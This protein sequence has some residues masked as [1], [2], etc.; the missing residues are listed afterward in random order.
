MES[1]MNPVQHSEIPS[2]QRDSALNKITFIQENRPDDEHASDLRL[3]LPAGNSTSVAIGKNIALTRQLIMG[4]TRGAG[5]GSHTK[6]HKD[7]P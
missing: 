1:R 6:H 7:Y 4:I 2:T 3:S 5:I